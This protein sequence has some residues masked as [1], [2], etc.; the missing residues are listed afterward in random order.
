MPL[1][2]LNVFFFKSVGGTLVISLNYRISCTRSRI[3]YWTV[4]YLSGI[5]R[6]SHLLSVSLF[7]S[8]SETLQSLRKSKKRNR[9]SL[10]NSESRNKSL[11]HRPNLM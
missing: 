5:V 2:Q 11:R 9:M 4:G 1:P 10:V 7:V 8:H 3:Y 6:S